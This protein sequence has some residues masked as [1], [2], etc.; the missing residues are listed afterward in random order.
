M[1]TFEHCKLPFLKISLLL[2]CFALTSF[3]VLLC[4]EQG[5]IKNKAFSKGFQLTCAEGGADKSYSLPIGY[6]AKKSTCQTCSRKVFVD[7][8]L[9]SSGSL[10]I[11]RKIRL[12]FPTFEN[13]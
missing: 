13:F 1:H 9:A 6:S 4:G 7:N 11:T 3:V 12:G 5:M 10:K 2:C 8:F